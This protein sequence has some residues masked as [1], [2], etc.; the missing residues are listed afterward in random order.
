[1]PETTVWGENEQR[2]VQVEIRVAELG[3]VVQERFWDEEA[4]RVDHQRCIA[5]VLR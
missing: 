3:V 1:M 5:V 2:I 4:G